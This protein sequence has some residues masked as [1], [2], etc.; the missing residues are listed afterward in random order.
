MATQHVDASVFFGA[1]G[2]LTCKQIYPAL[3]LIAWREDTYPPTRKS[4]FETGQG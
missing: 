1:M 2:D 4:I 3:L